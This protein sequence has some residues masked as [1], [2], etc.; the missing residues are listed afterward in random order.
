MARTVDDKKELIKKTKLNISLA[1]LELKDL[2][3][4]TKRLSRP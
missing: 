2:H 3:E 1:E 4:S